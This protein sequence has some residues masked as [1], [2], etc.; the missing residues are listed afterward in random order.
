M[1]QKIAIIGGGPAGLM[2]AHQLTNK[3][4][5]L[6]LF[7]AMPSLG[8][9]FLMAGK[10]GMNL[11]HNE[12]LDRFL[13]RYH[14]DDG[15]VS[16]AVKNFPPEAIRQWA[17]DLGI[18]TF[19]GS[20]GRIFPTDF[21]A[22]PLLRSWLRHLRAGG[23]QT[24]VHHRWIG[25]DQDKLV[26][27]TPD[28]LK[29]EKFD[30]VLFAMGGISWPKLGSDGGWINA[31]DQADIP[32]TPF[33]ASNCGFLKDWSDPFLQKF[34]GEPI[35][36]VALKSADDWTKGDFVI[37]KSG[38]EGS[39]IYTHSRNL[40]LQ[41]EKTGHAILHLDLAADR[42]LATLKQAL[43]KSRGS[44]SLSTHIKRVTR[45][46]PVK[47]ALLREIL[48]KETFNDMDKLA[49]AIKNLPL[50]LKATRPIDEA[51]SC[52]GGVDF[53]N[54]DNNLMITSQPG[55]FLAGEMLNW[56]APTGGYLLTGCFALG[57]QAGLG[58]DRW[59]QK[60]A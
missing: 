53:S 43:K 36:S 46:N 51:I 10:S 35:K 55:L 49:D 45:L 9:K 27:E 56:D 15:A 23:L 19:V 16:H 60:K 32:H 42:D 29:K 5:D 1:S 34:A 57:R 4:Y 6:H 3:D 31:F 41:L 40:R 33:K 44:K 38:V 8:R 18:E 2:A 26:F 11:T 50:P 39:A 21:K 28:G 20:S 52:A 14:D 12:P 58:M 54:T 7:D 59:L 48:D 37:S 22:A 30:A 13:T 24:H 17:A 47:I 25:W